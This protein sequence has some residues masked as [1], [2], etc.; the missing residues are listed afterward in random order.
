MSY[1]KTDAL[2][3]LFKNSK[4]KIVDE[5]GDL[6]V[7]FIKGLNSL[8]QE[9]ASDVNVDALVAERVR[10]IFYNGSAETSKPEGKTYDN[11][12]GGQSEVSEPKLTYDNLFTK[13][14]G[15]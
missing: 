13:G 1:I 11:P 15:K 8:E 7:D 5:T 12:A 10:D 9:N 2:K 6:S 14:E 3:E 4:G